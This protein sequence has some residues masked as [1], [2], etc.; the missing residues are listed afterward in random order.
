MG[1]HALSGTYNSVEAFNK[2]TAARLSP[3]MQGGKL[4]LKLNNLIVDGQQAVAEL[5][6]D[7]TQN[8]G[9]PFNNKY[10]WVLKYD[11]SGFIN[12][13]RA[14]LDGELVNEA[15]NENEGP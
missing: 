9:K 4:A 11:D 14:F 3:R 6:A 7:A 13:V 2:N 15:I 10:A 5:S 12:E 1:H 8:N